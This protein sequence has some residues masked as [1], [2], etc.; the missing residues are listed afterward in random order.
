M[1]FQCV[2]VILRELSEVDRPIRDI[3]LHLTIIIV[4]WESVIK[5]LEY[6]WILN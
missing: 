1:Q 2:V 5:P 4:Y 3:L 6:N